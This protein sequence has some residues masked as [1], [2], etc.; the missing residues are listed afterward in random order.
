M[1]NL[2]SKRAGGRAG[3]ASQ[4]G[5]GG[6]AP[7]GRLNGRFPGVTWGPM[8]SAA[9]LPSSARLVGRCPPP[10]GPTSARG[11]P[12]RAPIRV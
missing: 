4:G 10:K 2:P 12:I 5:S 6:G 11:A 3:G 9:V 1:H 7:P 8:T